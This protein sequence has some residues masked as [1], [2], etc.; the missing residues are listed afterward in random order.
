MSLSVP[1][2]A[3]LA[4]LGP[5][6]AQQ[7][8]DPERMGPGPEPVDL[9]H[10]ERATPAEPAWGGTLTIHVEDLPSVLNTALLNST[11]ARN[12]LHE[13]HASLVRRDWETWEYE[14]LVASGWE[15]ADTL[16]LEDGSVLHGVVA[17]VEAA[18]AETAEEPPPKLRLEP[19]DGGEPRVFEPDAVERV[20]RGTVITFTLRPGITWQDG[21]PLDVEDVLFSWRIAANPAVRCDW[22]RPYLARIESAEALGADRVRFTFAEQ[23]FNV[24]G[25][26]ADN[27][28][29]L[30]RHLY[31]LGDPDHPRHDPDASDAAC[32]KE[33]NENPCNTQWVGLGP[34]RV[35]RYSQQGVEAERWPG[36]FDPEDGG[37]ADRIVWRHVAND[38]AAFQALLSGELDFTVRI[39][40]DKYFGEAMAQPAFT[41]GLY[42]GYYYLGA[43]NFVPWNLRRPLLADLGVRQALA[44]AMDMEAFVENVAHGLAELPTGPQ[45]F[46][47]PSYDHSVARLGFDLERAVDRFTE[48][49][50]YDR[51]GDGVIDKDGAPFELEMLLTAGNTSAMTFARMYQESLARV[52]VRLVITSVDAATY[53]KRIQERDFDCG[54]QGWSVDATENDPTQLWHSAA[55]VPGGSNHSGVIDPHVD[56]LIARGA[57]ELDDET[58]WATWRELH[59]SLY[60]RVQPYLDR[61]LPPRKVALDRSIRGVQLF[62]L[63]PGDSLRRW[64]Y[65]AG[66]PGTRTTREPEPREKR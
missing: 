63:T 26:F 47:G 28:V 25:V 17:E 60:E 42:K 31:D 36:Y 66:T 7:D 2:L 12:M 4:L 3:L 56:A 21:H 9:F 27:L 45:C 52:G 32:A 23:Y 50:W 58:R 38:E 24:L 22:L 33:I 37:Y 40:S 8:G 20:E 18:D 30:P 57:R 64:Y 19:L 53:W 54:Q 10:P 43:F 1:V 39:G 14:P 48:A 46:F 16:Y 15:V 11:N 6:H 65:P 62:K 55:A 41:R 29:L 61:E 51:D 5:P 59:R 34:Y 13:L 35:T 49:G 44:H